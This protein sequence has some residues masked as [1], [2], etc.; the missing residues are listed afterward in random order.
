MKIACLNK[1]MVWWKRSRFTY[2]PSRWESHSA[3]LVSQDLALRRAMQIVKC[4]NWFLQN[5]QSSSTSA[6]VPLW[7]WVVD[8][9]HDPSSIVDNLH[10]LSDSNAWWIILV[11]VTH[12]HVYFKKIKLY[13]G[14]FFFTIPRWSQSNELQEFRALRALLRRARAAQTKQDCEQSQFYHLYTVNI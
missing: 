1:K 12:L 4:S 2:V 9:R 3:N 5:Q 7:I 6:F 8:D 14:V 10:V 11:P 13:L